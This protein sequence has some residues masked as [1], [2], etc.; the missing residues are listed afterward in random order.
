MV[1]QRDCFILYV[2]CPEKRIVMKLY[3]LNRTIEYISQTMKK[4]CVYMLHLVWGPKVSERFIFLYKICHV[5][6]SYRFQERAKE[7][8]NHNIIWVF[9]V[10][11]GSENAYP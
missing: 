8:I 10:Q 1:L 4:I 9:S 7:K 11:I 2:I 6:Y 3:S 5:I